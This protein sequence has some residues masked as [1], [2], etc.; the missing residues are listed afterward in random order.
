VHVLERLAFARIPASGAARKGVLTL[1]ENFDPAAVTAA[2]DAAALLVG[3]WNPQLMLGPLLGVP[4]L[5]IT[6]PASVSPHLDLAYRA[7]RA[8]D[9]PLITVEDD[10]F[11]LVKALAAR[12]T[13]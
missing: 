11:E 9:T 13:A 8:L 5:A 1:P 12:V 7:A 10:Q 2:V 4:T 6:T 3:P